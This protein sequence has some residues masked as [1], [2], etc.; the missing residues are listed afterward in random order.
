MRLKS[1]IKLLDE[2]EG[3]G[4]PAKKGDRVIYNLK[5]FLNRSD[6][7]PVNQRQAEFLPLGMIRA[8]DGYR[9]VDHE[10]ILGSREAMAGVEYSLTGMRRNGYRKVRVSPHLAYR[11]KGLPD[12]I[13][14]D[15]V[16]IIELWLRELIRPES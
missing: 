3:V 7:V 4:E 2:R 9:F 16:L 5:I 11:D 13:P 6:E 8:V 15:A 10:T 12:L 1:G 14:R